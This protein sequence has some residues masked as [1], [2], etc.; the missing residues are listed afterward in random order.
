M[1]ASCAQEGEFSL[2]RLQIF[3]PGVELALL[4]DTFL[5]SIAPMP[6]LMAD[7]AALAAEPRGSGSAPSRGE[8]SAAAAASPPDQLPVALPHLGSAGSS[9]EPLARDE[10]STSVFDMGAIDIGTSM[11]DMGTTSP[12]H[13]DGAVSPSGS[14]RAS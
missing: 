11:Y 8:A 4:L 6:E 12:A 13:S 2:Y 5:A 10:S 1:S 14:V 9:T 3:P 7:A